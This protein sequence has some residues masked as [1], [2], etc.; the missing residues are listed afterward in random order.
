MKSLLI[1]LTAGAALTAGLATAASAAPGGYGAPNHAPAYG[2]RHGG[3]QYGPQRG[4]V[5]A[6]AWISIAQRKANLERR[7]DMGQRSG[8]LSRNEAFRLRAEF[9]DL[10]RLEHHYRR[11][12][13]TRWEMADLD[14]RMDRLSA[15]I[16]VER[17]DDDRRYGQ[18]YGQG[19]GYGY[20]R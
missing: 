15:R 1:A 7:I 12:G 17:R 4:Q 11:G 5:R 13:L 14:R 20:R 8:S 2:A 3:D 10:R 18:G 9:N 16:Y 19:Q 6:P